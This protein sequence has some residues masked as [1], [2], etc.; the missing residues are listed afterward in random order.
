MDIETSN[1]LNGTGRIFQSIELLLPRIH[2]ATPRSPDT[3]YGAATIYANLHL[4]AKD[5]KVTHGIA[6]GSIPF[7]R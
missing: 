7:Q 5:G 2:T 6:L 1:L 3:L 4:F